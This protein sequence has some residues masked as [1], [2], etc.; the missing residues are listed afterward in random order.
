M[1]A[2]WL[3]RLLICSVRA[4]AAV[5][6]AVQTRRQ[7]LA[8]AVAVRAPTCMLRL[9]A[10]QAG[11]VQKGMLCLAAAAAPLQ[12]ASCQLP[13]ARGATMLQGLELPWPTPLRLQQ[14]VLQH[15]GSKVRGLPGELGPASMVQQHLEV[16]WLRAGSGALLPAA[17]LVTRASQHPCNAQQ[18]A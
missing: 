11:D 14:S 15:W 16:L 8:V 12:S 5:A 4:A 18:V 6:E 2:A 17:G 10:G 9:A 1:A 3:M 13:S 7:R